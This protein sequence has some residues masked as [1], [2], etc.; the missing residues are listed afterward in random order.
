MMT[1]M[2]YYGPMKSSGQRVNTP[3]FNATGLDFWETTDWCGTCWKTSCM[4]LLL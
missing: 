1:Q 3:L 4:Y 2:S